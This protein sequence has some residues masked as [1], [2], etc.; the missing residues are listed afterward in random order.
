[1]LRAAAKVRR[2]RPRIDVPSD[3]RL[4]AQQTMLR[5]LLTRRLKRS[6]SIPGALPWYRRTSFW[7]VVISALMTALA[8]AIVVL[9][10]T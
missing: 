2:G 3:V 6:R 1:M 5:S 9:F 10:T 7:V 8:A 4:L